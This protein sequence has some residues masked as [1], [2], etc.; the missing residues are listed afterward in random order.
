MVVV[1]WRE[2]WLKPL[3]NFDIESDVCNSCKLALRDRD[4]VTS[5][6]FCEIGVMHNHCAD[7]HIFKTHKKDVENKIELHKD[8]RLHDYQWCINDANCNSSSSSYHP[9]AS[10][11]SLVQN[12]YEWIES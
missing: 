10:N 11:Y 7:Q 12:V 8:R 1:L 2:S 6:E 5:C 3:S 4:M 9:I